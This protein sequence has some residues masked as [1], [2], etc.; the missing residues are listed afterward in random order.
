MSRRTKAVRLCVLAMVVYSLVLLVG[1]SNALS[2]TVAPHKLPLRQ[3]HRERMAVIGGPSSLRRFPHE[4]VLVRMLDESSNI[5]SF[6]NDAADGSDASS[7]PKFQIAPSADA[8][9]NTPAAAKSSE[10][11]S[12]LSRGGE[13]SASSVPAS[14]STASQSSVASHNN[15]Q[16]SSAAVE[17][18]SSS[19]S[20]SGTSS[21]SN[22]AT[23]SSS[24]APLLFS[25]SYSSE[26]S[27]P[28]ASSGSSSASSSSASS[29]SSESSSSSASSSSNSSASSSSAS[30]RSSE[31]SSSSASSGSSKSLASSSIQSTIILTGFVTRTL[32]LVYSRLSH[33]S[34]DDIIKSF[35]ARYG[36][37]ATIKLIA[38]SIEV[39][40]NN[41]YWQQVTPSS[42]AS[43]SGI[44]RSFISATTDRAVLDVFVTEANKDGIEGVLLAK[45]WENTNAK[46]SKTWI[47]GLVF[48][49]AVSGAAG[50]LIVYQVVMRRQ[51][52]RRNLMYADTGLYEDLEMRHEKSNAM[53][54]PN[55]SSVVP[56]LSMRTRSALD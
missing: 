30:S 6:S 16:G 2:I 18:R 7:A 9:S 4:N 35:A 52:R 37:S 36:V 22:S 10:Y 12:S 51:Y 56:P 49:I 31:S 19:S 44:F 34:A 50:V 13:K 5:S 17:G 15:S 29:Y 3:A 41:D 48:A 14:S 39:E 40:N 25:S 46:A 1:N 21:A 28:S 8:S 53:G 27:S 23:S 38:R 47:V 26:S 33:H 54:N 43:R 20:G 24:S 45:D 55:A 11:S 32:T 42:I